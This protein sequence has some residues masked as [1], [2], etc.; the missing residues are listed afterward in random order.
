MKKDVEIQT[1]SGEG[2]VKDIW[3]SELG[4]LMVK[5]LLKEDNTFINY[6]IGTFNSDDNIFTESIKKTK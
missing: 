5:V 2:V 1:P 3:V 6:N 4:Y